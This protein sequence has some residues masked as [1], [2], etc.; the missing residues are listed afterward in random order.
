M[1]THAPGRHDA[2]QLEVEVDGAV[3]W[4]AVRAEKEV[5]MPICATWHGMP[6]HT[7]RTEQGVQDARLS[8]SSNLHF[9]PLT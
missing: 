9:V 2:G 7:G 4:E 5:A 8:Y 6:V 1:L 3:L